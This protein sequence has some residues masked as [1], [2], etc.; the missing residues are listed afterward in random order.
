MSVPDWLG[1][2]TGDIGGEAG[3]DAPGI[4]Q[5]GGP[6]GGER[7][8]DLS[9]RWVHGRIILSGMR[10]AW[11]AL[12][13]GVMAVVATGRAQQP[14]PQPTFR[15]NVTMVTTDVIARDS[16]GRFVADLTRDD[17][18]I[19]E[20]G[21]PQQVASFVLVH[22][23]RVFNLLEPQAA[24][25]ADEG[26][27]L[28]PQKRPADPGSGR[29]ILIFVDDLHFEAQYTPHVRRIVQQ[30]ADTLLHDGDLVSMVSSG[31]SA[32]EINPTLDRKL[33]AS[34]ASKIRGSQEP[35]DELFKMMETSQ[36]PGDIRFRAQ[37][38][39]QTV[40]NMVAS[41]DEVRN[42]RKAIIYISTGYDFDPFAESRN[43]ND[44]IQGGRFADPTRALIDQE[45]PYF[46]MGAV[47]AD[48][49]LYRF[50]R[51]LTLSA[52]RVNASLFTVDPRGVAGITDAGQYLDQS[53]WRTFLQK[54]QSS[55][56][57]IAEETGGFPVVND[58]DFQTAF[59]RID[60]ETSDYYVLGFYSS[61]PDPGKRTRALEVKVTRPNISVASR[62][63][64][65][66]KAEGKAPPPQRPASTPKKKP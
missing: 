48:V 3:Q 44:H 57:Y 20:D 13:A 27:V 7:A 10:R 2:R 51:E 46:H 17:F 43:S 29:V 12:A 34:A 32:I 16:A 4:D 6:G 25:F 60:A 37:V 14:A 39:F 8:Q 62:K 45:N 18:T 50:M 36:G 24:N 38:A 55:L 52:N 23:G 59:K 22:G 1:V 31:P 66:L 61:N 65:S 64:Y 28:P 9:A 63:A 54:T 19:T 33:I 58:N 53:E 49:D 5:R 47:T 56:R 40:Y 11:L 42:R 35:P 15:S 21:Q 41:L 26:I 30:L